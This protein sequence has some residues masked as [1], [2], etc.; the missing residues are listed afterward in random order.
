MQ[1]KSNILR[2]SDLFSGLGGFHVA[3]DGLGGTCVFA[4]EIQ[5]HLQGLYEQNFGIRPHGD[6]K[7]IK[8]NDVPDHDL[9]CAGFPCQPFSKAGDQLGFECTKQ[10][11]LFFTVVKILRAKR[12]TLFILENVPN[13]LKHDEG[14]TYEKIKQ[15]LE[16][17]GYT[18][19][20]ARLSPHQFGV[21]QIRERAYIVGSLL[22]LDAFKWP[23]P[24]NA[25]TSISKVLDKQPLDAKQLSSQVSDCLNVWNNFLHASTEVKEL[26]SFP[27][28]SMEFGA[29]YP[30]EDKTPHAILKA[31]GTR[32]LAKYHGSHGVALNSLDPDERW[33]A[34]PS[35]ARTAQKKFPKWKIDFIRQ[36]R[37]FYASNRHW[38]DPWLPNILR[39]PSSLQKFEWNV[40]GGQREIWNYVLQFRASG[41]R[42]KRPT[43]APSLVAMTETQVPIIGWEKR[44]MTPRECSRL[45]SLSILKLPETSGRAFEALGNAVN[46]EVVKAIVKN[47]LS[48]SSGKHNVIASRAHSIAPLSYAW[49]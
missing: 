28:W 22:G 39:F 43:T 27:I 19:D 21:P 38:I 41:V 37:E 33:A 5:E 48:E 2:F 24:S 13:I 10:G 1:K 42:V 34:L 32:G 18:V 12:P 47:L 46:T 29:T 30:Y 14:R 49:M 15:H 45:Q 17:I 31:E 9:L 25:E 11:D 23:V 7:A 3:I 8:P 36:N 20:A 35:H 6:I 16:N 4:A 40:K 44:Y 26:P